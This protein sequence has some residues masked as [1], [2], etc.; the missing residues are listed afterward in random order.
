MGPSF[1][2]AS[3][4]SLE[5]TMNEY[6][7]VFVDGILRAARE[8]DGVVEMTRWFKAF[9]FDVASEFMSC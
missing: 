9:S 8:N 4:K 5:P 2:T 3:L 7:Q 1:S 6:V